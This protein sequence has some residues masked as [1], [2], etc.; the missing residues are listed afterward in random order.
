MPS[1]KSI[2]TGNPIIRNKFTCDPTALV[3]ND[4][5]YLF[6]GHDEAPIGVENYVMNDWLCF[7]S[8]DMIT[9]KEYPIPLQAKDF[10]WAKGDAYAS[11][12]IERNGKFYWYVAVSDAA[13]GGKAIGV[14]SS[15]DPAGPY[16]DEKGTALITHNMLP[17]TT[18]E[19]AN[20][21][22]SVIIDNDGQAYIFW[23]NETC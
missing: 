10:K 7:S 1:R 11:K 12:L 16:H 21:D 3:Y 2:N 5:V 20:L 17:A 13:A 9:W 18:N 19:K 8:S 22:P 15:T 14:A 6:T 23:G 4:M